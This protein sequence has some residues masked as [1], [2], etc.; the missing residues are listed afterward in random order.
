[1]DLKP[2]GELIIFHGA[3]YKPAAAPFPNH[4][5][6]GVLETLSIKAVFNCLTNVY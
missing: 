3:E 5:H 2:Q 4:P 1:M 6:A